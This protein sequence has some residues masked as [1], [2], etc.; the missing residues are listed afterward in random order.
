MRT[1]LREALNAGRVGKSRDSR[2]ISRFIMCCQRRDRLGV[3]NTAPP[4]DRGKLV[5]LIAGS[6]RQSL[7]MA[8]D[9]DEAFITRSLNVKPKTTEQHTQW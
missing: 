6:K 8:G 9:D 7:L 1:H 5:T 4:Q 3:M 2:P